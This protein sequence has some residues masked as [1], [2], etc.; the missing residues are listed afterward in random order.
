M[1]T[2]IDDLETYVGGSA[3]CI[4]R[5]LAHPGLE[6]LPIAIDARVDVYGDTVNG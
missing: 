1:A 4:E 2:E 3:A 5:V 6:A